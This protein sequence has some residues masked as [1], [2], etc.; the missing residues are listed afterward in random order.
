MTDLDLNK[1]REIAE[2]AMTTPGPWSEYL[3]TFDPPTVIAL[4]DKIERLRTTLDDIKSIAKRSP[5]CDKY[6]DDS[7][8]SCGWRSDLLGIKAVLGNE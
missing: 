6:D 7:G 4:I 3:L 8:I 2:A 5:N 1:L